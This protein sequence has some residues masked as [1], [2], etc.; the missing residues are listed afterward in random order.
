ML[1]TLRGRRDRTP[2]L[3]LTARDSLEER[4]RGSNAG[5][6]D[7]LTKPFAMRESMRRALRRQ[8]VV[9]FAVVATTRIATFGAV[10]CYV[11]WRSLVRQVDRELT[12]HAA[13]VARALQPVGDGTF[14][15]I[16]PADVRDAFTMAGN[17]SGSWRRCGTLFGPPRMGVGRPGAAPIARGSH[18]P[19]AR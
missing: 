12:V 18:A 9:L 13:T 3:I 11:F 19:P 17:H 1:A 16:I 6:D 8:L 10:V 7:Y 2:I 5:A 4:V 14:D 15:L